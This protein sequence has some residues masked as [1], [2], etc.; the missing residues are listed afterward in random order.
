MSAITRRVANG[1][2]LG[3]LAGTRSFAKPPPPSLR[4]TDDAP[5]ILLPFFVAQELDLWKKSGIDMTPIP[6]IVGTPNLLTV[7]N[8]AID[9]GMAATVSIAIAALNGVAVRVLGTFVRSEAMELCCTKSI[10]RPNQIAGKRI[11]VLQGTVSHYYLH[12]LMEKYGLPAASVSVTS[13]G[14]AEMMAALKA[15]QIDGFVWQEPMLT[16]GVAADSSKFHR[17]R[18]PGLVQLTACLITS[19]EALAQR[20]ATLV[21]ALRALRQAYDYIGSNPDEAVKIGVRRSGIDEAAFSD[22]VRR[23]T[24]SLEFDGP[25]YTLRL[26]MTRFGRCRKDWRSLERRSPGSLL[27]SR[28]MCSLSPFEADPREPCRQFHALC[29]GIR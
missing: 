18:E 5:V 25:A 9:I 2:L 15:G 26:S 20:R 21:Q 14:P 29:S 4:I 16:R 22:S 23:M 24:L 17:L 3:G 13:M 8:G 7:S 11:A 6:S 10:E 1:F 19:S 12:L 28:P 27:T